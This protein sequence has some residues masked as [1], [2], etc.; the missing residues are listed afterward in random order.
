MRIHQLCGLQVT[1]LLRSVLRS[2]EGLSFTSNVTCSVQETKS[3]KGM[4]TPQNDSG[5]QPG[6]L[7]TSSYRRRTHAM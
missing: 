3:G 6:S 7:A 4:C 5:S 1:R 2:S